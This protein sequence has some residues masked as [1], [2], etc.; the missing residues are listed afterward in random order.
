[1]NENKKDRENSLKYWP[2]GN[3]DDDDWNKLPS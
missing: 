2:C 1:M 3:C